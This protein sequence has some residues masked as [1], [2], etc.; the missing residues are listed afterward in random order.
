MSFN[1]DKTEIMLFSNTDV[2]YN[3][4]FSFNGNNIPITMSYKQLGVTLS[5]DAKWNNHIENIILKVS[6]HSGILRRLK[7]RLSRQNLEKKF[8]LSIY[9]ANF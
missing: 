1:L 9:P 8:V 3:F 5:S 7:Y 6:R 4:N 2:R